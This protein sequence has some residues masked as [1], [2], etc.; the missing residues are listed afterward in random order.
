M[1][2][3]DLILD[4]HRHHLAALNQWDR[5]VVESFFIQLSGGQGFTEKQ[6]LLAVR[7]AKKHS[8]LLAESFGKNISNILENPTYSLPIRNLVKTKHINIIENGIY[9][10]CVEAV[11]PYNDEYIS[12]FRKN[13]EIN[14]TGVWD[15]NRRAWIF[16]LNE[17]NLNF[18]VDF[19]ERENF[20]VDHE[21]AKYSQEV[22]K[23][24]ENIDAHIP[25]LVLDNNRPK[26]TNFY[27]KSED[28]AKFDILSS[29]FEARKRGVYVW[30]ELISQ[31]LESNSVSEITRNFLKSNPAENYQIFSEN[32]PISDITPLMLHLS[33]TL[34]VLPGGSELEKL[35]EWYNHLKTIGVADKEISV[36]FRLSSK[37][38]QKFNEFV[39]SNGINKPITDC[40][41]FVFVSGKLPKTI[42]KSGIKF[43]S[44][45]NLGFSNAHYTLKSYL[46]NQENVITYNNK[47]EKKDNYFVFL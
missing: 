26:L 41:K 10:K 6:S 39:K 27:E 19:A 30:D 14:L 37:C 38:N 9:K 40:T 44:V 12:A 31:Y 15:P 21:F 46:K 36:M 23:I 16:P 3:E 20:I 28:F 13:K 33:P 35:S 18:L 7:I 5:G 8:N 47:K 32:H 42:L 25:L 11:F 29:V 2:I 17:A 45:V 4:L 34:V 1:H 43:H 24:K 22:K